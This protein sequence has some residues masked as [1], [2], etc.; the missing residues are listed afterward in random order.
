MCGALVVH[1]LMSILY[2]WVD[3][4]FPGVGANDLGHK[5]R[6]GAGY[7]VL[8]V[9][10]GMFGYN[11]GRICRALRKVYNKGIGKKQHV[12]SGS[13]MF[14][15]VFGDGSNFL[16]SYRLEDNPNYTNLSYTVNILHL[17][18]HYPSHPDSSLSFSPPPVDTNRPLK[19]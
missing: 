2:F 1:Q 10:F 5:L 8:A 11:Y 6:H 3:D 17:F 12:G 9:L 15:E 16:S 19:P 14:R 13:K 4:V 18:R 7:L